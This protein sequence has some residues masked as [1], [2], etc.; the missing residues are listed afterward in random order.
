MPKLKVKYD[1]YHKTG[2]GYPQCYMCDGDIKEGQQRLQMTRHW[3]NHPSIH[4]ECLE[5]ALTQFETQK[6]T[7]KLAYENK[8]KQKK[9]DKE[10]S[11]AELKEARKI[12]NWKKTIIKDALKKIGLRVTKLS[13]TN[14]HDWGANGKGDIIRI[15]RPW[16]SSSTSSTHCSSFLWIRLDQADCY[17]VKPNGRSYYLHDINE[18]IGSDH[19]KISLADPDAI[20]KIAEAME[21]LKEGDWSAYLKKSKK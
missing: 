20:D 10:K 8:I 4:K 9:I 18:L 17:V 3:R 15:G 19:K 5:K 7:I 6:D 16:S 14:P 13:I 12:R 11:Q 2:G 1:I 21:N